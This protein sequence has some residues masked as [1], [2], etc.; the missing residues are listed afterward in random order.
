MAQAAREVAGFAGSARDLA[1]LVADRAAEGERDRHLAPDVVEA[2]RVACLFRML[3]PAAIGGGEADPAD[4]LAAIESIAA[5][6]GSAGWCVAVCS[7]AGLIAARLPEGAAREIAGHADAISCGVFAP[8]GRATVVGG[9]LELSGRW[10]LASGV[11][12]ADWVGLG[13]L[14][15]EGDGPPAFR[16]A[17]LPRPEV[18]VIDTW[19]ALG[20][21]ATSSHDVAVEAATVPLERSTSLFTDEPTFDGALYRFPVF[22]VLALAIAAVCTG[23]ARSA[24]D[25]V[26]ELASEK[27]PAGSRRKLAER[28]AAQARVAEAEAALRASRALVAEAVGEAWERARADGEVDVERRLALRLAAT[29]AAHA[30]AATTAAAHELAG[31]S[32]VYEG[33]PLER[34]MRDITVATRHMLVAP[35]TNEL[36]G[37]LLLG[38]QTDTTQ[39]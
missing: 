12:H 7:T 29:H 11:A 32:G 33:S 34:A 30:A 13:C 18:E 25:A 8:K 9:E 4:A 22:G 14:V 36:T 16:Y 21:R 37:R 1:P 3:V 19:R 38:V 6:D 28:G 27:T 24:L 26:V 23:I 2:L 39:L 17:I 20:L 31:V 10:P 15:E 5:A 35:A